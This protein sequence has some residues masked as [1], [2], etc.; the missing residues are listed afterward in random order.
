MGFD[1]FCDVCNGFHFLGPVH[2]QEFFLHPI[3]LFCI[4]LSATSLWTK[5]HPQFASKMGTYVSHNFFLTTEVACKYV[6]R[7]YC[8]KFVQVI[9]GVIQLIPKTLMKG[10]VMGSHHGLLAAACW[11]QRHGKVVPKLSAPT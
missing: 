5:F 1:G 7:M 9:F 8:E 11:Y 4:S 6:R 10:F 2:R 3:P